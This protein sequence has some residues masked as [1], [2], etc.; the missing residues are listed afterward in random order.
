MNKWLK[1]F[2][3]VIALFAALGTIWMALTMHRQHLAAEETKIDNRIRAA[4]DSL[5]RA[6]NDDDSTSASTDSAM[7]DLGEA[8]N[9]KFQNDLEKSKELRNNFAEELVRL[10]QKNSVDFGQDGNLQLDLRALNE[11][12]EEYPEM[13]KKQVNGNV[14][15]IY[16]Y[17][18]AL[19]ELHKREP[20]FVESAKLLRNGWIDDEK[21]VLKNEKDRSLL[22][23]ISS[24]YDK[25]F[26]ILRESINAAAANNA[27]KKYI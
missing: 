22:R 4:Y 13:L 17:S 21:I 10:F 2:T 18:L 25:H 16:R 19:R 26:Q 11:W 7:K 9:S 14:N 8:I 20:Q 27:D 12:K 24:L 5:L 6:H 3:V 1:I 15:I 23:N